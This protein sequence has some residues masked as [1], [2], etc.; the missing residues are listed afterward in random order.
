MAAESFIPEDWAT[1]EPGPKHWT[2][3]SRSDDPAARAVHE[4]TGTGPG[5]GKTFHFLFG[6]RT[7]R[8]QDR[9]MLA[10]ELAHIDDDVAVLRAAGYTVVVDRQATREDLT[11]AVADK[12]TAGLY[13]SGHGGADGR[14]QTC[15]GTLVGPADID[16]ATVTPGLRL[17]VLGACY[18]GAYAPAWRTAFGGFPLVAGWGRPVTLERAVD[19]L[20][21]GPE[22]E[23][24]LD[25][26]IAHWL[27][28]DAPIPA[29]SAP[30]GLAPAASTGGRTKGLARRIRPVT[31]RLGATWEQQDT[32]YTIMVPLPGGRTHLVR[33]FVVDGTDPFSE[34]VAL[35][36]V[37]AEVGPTS[38]LITPER[39]LTRTA[40]PG[41][42]RIALVTGDTDVPKIVTQSFTPLAGTSSQ[43]LAAHCFQ[44]AL[45]AD[46][47][48]RAIFGTDQG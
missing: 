9:S 23:I 39:L 28:T 43:Q 14:L 38:P 19:F 12:G 35:C 17:V 34:G 36:G 5:D 13:W 27:L 6:Y 31:D 29:P 24:G 1:A 4:P 32:H 22:P 25:D 41:Y 30:A 7:G 44:V 18:V 48:E 21:A 15:D 26:L 40:F 45:H 8:E 20:E 46:T 10:E 16:P 42:G 3:D 47:L 33:L 11:E 2:A 37:E